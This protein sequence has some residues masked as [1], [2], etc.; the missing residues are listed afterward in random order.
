MVRFT[1]RQCAYFRAIAE[2]GG[3]AQAARALNMSQPSIAQALEKLEEI[4]NLTLF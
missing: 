4:T 2:H 1:L 3:I